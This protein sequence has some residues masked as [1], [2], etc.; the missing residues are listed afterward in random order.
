MLVVIFTH[1]APQIPG[2]EGRAG[3]ATI[4]DPDQ[5]IDLSVL[6]KALSKS[7]PFYAQPIFIRIASKMDLTG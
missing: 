5:S 7:L 4:L 2:T 3:M 6:G 1:V